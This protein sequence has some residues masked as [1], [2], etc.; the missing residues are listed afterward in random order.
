MTSA[1]RIAVVMLVAPAAWASGSS[2]SAAAVTFFEE[3]VRD[4]RIIFQGKL[5]VVHFGGGFEDCRPYSFELS[6]CEA[7]VLVVDLA[8][9]VQLFEQVC[10]EGGNLGVLWAICWRPVRVSEEIDHGLGFVVGG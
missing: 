3:Q 4:R 7:L 5:T 2:H 1:E 8:I 9:G 10:L 6:W